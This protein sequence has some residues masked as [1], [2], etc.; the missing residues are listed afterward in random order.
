[1]EIVCDIYKTTT[2]VSQLLIIVNEKQLSDQD[3]LFLIEK[4]KN[5]IMDIGG[6]DPPTSRMQS[7]R[8]T[9]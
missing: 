4:E 9:N 1:M 2:L 7:A 3:Q 5:K 8:S 6:F